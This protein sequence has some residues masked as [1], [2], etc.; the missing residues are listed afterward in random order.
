[1]QDISQMQHMKRSPEQPMQE[2]RLVTGL[3][4]THTHSSARASICQQILS[5]SSQQDTIAK[6]NVWEHLLLCSRGRT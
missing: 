4:G 6:R 5:E 3:R 2:L 1:M